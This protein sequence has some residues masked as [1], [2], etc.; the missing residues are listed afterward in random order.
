MFCESNTNVL[1]EAFL[2]AFF[3]LHAHKENKYVW[4]SLWNSSP[5]LCVGFERP[6]RAF[7]L[8]RPRWLAHYTGI[9]QR[10]LN[11]FG[12]R[13]HHPFSCVMIFCEVMKLLDT[14]QFSEV[15]AFL[16]VA[17]PLLLG[18]ALTGVNSPHLLQP[19]LLRERFMIEQS[20]LSQ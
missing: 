3:Q 19:E 17:L 16:P 12:P 11:H 2:T 10:C 5:C 9:Q 18:H 7:L 1:A 6:E 15:L 14:L 4:K 20:L 13:T 8:K